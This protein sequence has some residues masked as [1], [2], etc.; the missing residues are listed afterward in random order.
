MTNDPASHV[1][2]PKRVAAG[3]RNRA[4]RG[5]LTESGR[6]KL[7]ESAL[8]H[9]PW[10]H[11]TG[12]RTDVG[13]VYASRNGKRR[14]KGEYS[15]RELIHIF[16]EMQC[17]LVAIQ[18]RRQALEAQMAK[19]ASPSPNGTATPAPAS[20]NSPTTAPN[21]SATDSGQRAVTEAERPRSAQPNS[22]NHQTEK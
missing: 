3:Y 4:L 10:E 7:R 8:L 2:N 21:P 16:Y 19:A 18:Q 11:S 13:K 15:R 20:T 12:P 9:R 6:Q 5:P 17:E 22:Q 14:Q 1:P